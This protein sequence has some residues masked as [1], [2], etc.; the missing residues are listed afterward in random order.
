ML[1]HESIIVIFFNSD[2]MFISQKI[3]IG[4]VNEAEKFVFAG[5]CVLKNYRYRFIG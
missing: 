5:C 2:L 1:N 4:L 3:E